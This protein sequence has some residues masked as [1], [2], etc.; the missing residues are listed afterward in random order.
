MNQIADS[1]FRI[2]KWAITRSHAP[3]QETENRKLEIADHKSQITNEP[4]ARW[5]NN[6]ILNRL[7]AGFSSD[8]E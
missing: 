4:M 2:P 8:Y 5:P 1:E 3:R 7:E 6:P